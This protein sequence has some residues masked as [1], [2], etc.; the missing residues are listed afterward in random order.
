MPWAGPAACAGP[1]LSL[2]NLRGLVGATLD[3]RTAV[4]RPAQENA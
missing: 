3:R 1:A 2:L 4:T